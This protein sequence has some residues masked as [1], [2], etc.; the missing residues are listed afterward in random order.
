MQQ[1]L[2]PALAFM[3]AFALTPLIRRL[4][5]RVGAMDYPGG[6]KKH[7][8]AMPLL[9]GVAVYL[10]FW[11]TAALILT[12]MPGGEKLW[13]LFWGSSLILLLGLYDDIKGLSYKVKFAGQFAAALILLAYNIRIEFVTIPF[14]NM[15]ILGIFVVPLTLLWVV[16]VT[17]AVNLADGVDGLATGISIIAAAVMCALSFGEFPLIALLA[18]SLAGAALGF[19]PHNFAPARIF[20]GDSG[21]LFL[22]FMLAAFS[23]LTVTKQATFTT[24]VIPVLILGLPICDTCYAMFR[25]LRSRRPIFQADNGHIHHRLLDMGLGPRRTVMVLY[26]SSI[27]FGGAAIVFERLAFGVS[28]FYFIPLVFAFFALGLKYLDNVSAFFVAAGGIITPAKE[29]KPKGEDFHK[30]FPS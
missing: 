24:L 4:A 15:V 3:L 1:F 7:G 11:I 14:Q 13:G 16:G 18:L 8:Q 21:S 10:A 28:N 22:G 26:F 17:N 6:R 5:Q 27:Y 25:R 12:Y 29:E 30:N 20:L 9:G 19:L 23:I 2:A